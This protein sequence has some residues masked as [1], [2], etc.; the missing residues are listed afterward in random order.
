MPFKALKKFISISIIITFISTNSIYASPDFKPVLKN[1]EEKNSISA[2]LRVPLFSDPDR[3]KQAIRLLAQTTDARPIDVVSLFASRSEFKNGVKVKGRPRQDIERDIIQNILDLQILGEKPNDY[4]VAADL[5]PT[6]WAY[7]AGLYTHGEMR[8]RPF[9]ENYRKYILGNVTQDQLM[10][11]A[12]Q[13]AREDE[14]VRSSITNTDKEIEEYIDEKVVK[15]LEK[16]VTKQIK[17]L[18]SDSVNRRLESIGNNEL[19][20]VCDIERNKL[21]K[22]RALA[23]DSL[24]KIEMA[25]LKALE[26]EAR[27]DRLKSFRKEEINNRYAEKFCNKNIKRVANAIAAVLD[28]EPDILGHPL[29]DDLT[30]LYVLNVVRTV[31]KAVLLKDP[32]APTFDPYAETNAKANEIAID[33]ARKESANSVMDPKEETKRLM[34]FAIGGGVIDLNS[35]VLRADYKADPEYFIEHHFNKA[36]ATEFAS[37]YFEEDFE[38][39]YEETVKS[40]AKIR[41]V[42]FLD[43][44]GEAV[45]DLMLMWQLMRVNPNLSIYVVP[46]VQ[47]LGNDISYDEVIDIISGT[48][49]FGELKGMLGK[50]FYIIDKGPQ[51]QGVDGKRISKEL[52]DVLQGGPDE[53]T[54]GMFAG[55]ANFETTQGWNIPRYYKLMAKGAGM[56]MATGLPQK[57]QAFI[58][59]YVPAGVTVGTGDSYLFRKTDL[60][61]T[62]EE[63]YSSRQTLM[64]FE[65]AVHSKSYRSRVDGYWRE[66]DVNERIIEQAFESGK[67]FA[68]IV[69]S[70]D[71]ELYESLIKLGLVKRIDKA[72]LRKDRV[73]EVILGKDGLK[74]DF[75]KDVERLAGIEDLVEAQR[76]PDNEE[77]EK[78]AYS[79]LCAIA[80]RAAAEI[81]KSWA[82]INQEEFNRTFGSEQFITVAGRGKRFSDLVHKGLFI[83]LQG[84]PNLRLAI[85]GSYKTPGTKPTIFISM[86]QLRWIL[87]DEFIP[88]LIKEVEQLGDSDKLPAGWSEGILPEDKVDPEKRKK[89]FTEDAR[90]IL[91]KPYGPGYYL[92][93]G[94]AILAEKELLDKTAYKQIVFGEMGSVQDLKKS[95]ASLITYMEAVIGN[96]LITAGG[97]KAGRIKKGE[98]EISKK[99]NFF[100]EDGK[101]VAL[102]DWDYIT[103]DGQKEL[104]R[105]AV[106]LKNWLVLPGREQKRLRDKFAIDAKGNVLINSNTVI[107]R[108]N[109]AG[110]FEAYNNRKDRP[111]DKKTKMHLDLA[112]DFIKLVTDALKQRKFNGQWPIGF[113][114]VGEAPSSLKDMAKQTQFSNQYRAQLVERLREL[115]DDKSSD[116]KPISVEEDANP[117]IYFGENADFKFSDLRRIF[118]GTAKLSGNVYL[119]NKVRIGKGAA[120]SNG[121]RLSGE[122]TLGDSVTVSK[123]V[124]EGP[125]EI[126][127]GCS[128]NGTVVC[129]GSSTITENITGLM[130]QEVSLAEAL[131]NPSL[132]YANNEFYKTIKDK[133]YTSLATALTYILGMDGGTQRAQVLLEDLSG[134]SLNDYGK[135]LRKMIIVSPVLEKQLQVF[136]LIMSISNNA[137]ILDYQS[138]GELNHGII[139]EAIDEKLFDFSKLMHSSR[140][141]GLYATMY[142]DEWTKSQEKTLEFFA[143]MFD[144][145]G[146]D[147][148]KKR[149]IMVDLIDHYS[150]TSDDI[151]KIY[152]ATFKEDIVQDMVENLGNESVAKLVSVLIGAE[153]SDRLSIKSKEESGMKEAKEELKR[154]LELVL[155]NGAYQ[156]LLAIFGNVRGTINSFV[157]AVIKNT[158]QTFEEAILADSNPLYHITDVYEKPRILGIMGGTGGTP[159]LLMENLLS[160]LFRGDVTM[161]VVGSPHDDGGSSRLAQDKLKAYGGYMPSPGDSMNV[162]SALTKKEGDVAEAKRNVIRTRFAKDLPPDTSFREKML[163]IL[164]NETKALIGKGLENAPIDW[165]YFARYTLNI[166]GILD[167]ELIKPGYITLAGGSVGNFIFIA[168]HIKQK[169]I[170][171]AGRVYENTFNDS[172]EK[173][174]Q[175]LGLSDNFILPSTLDPATLYAKLEAFELLVDGKSVKCKI[176]NEE[177]KKESVE[178]LFPQMKA[179]LQSGGDPIITTVG[180]KVIELNKYPDSSLLTCQINGIRARVI[181]DFGGIISRENSKTIVDMTW[182]PEDKKQETFK[183]KQ[184]N[185]TAHYSIIEGRLF[186]ALVENTR[187]GD[188][189]K[190]KNYIGY[191]EEFK[192]GKPEDSLTARVQISDKKSDKNGYQVTIRLDAKGQGTTVYFKDTPVILRSRLIIEQ[193]NITESVHTSGIIDAGLIDRASPTPNKKVLD[194]I[195]NTQEAIVLGPGSLM[196]STLPVL[197]VPEIVDAI[198]KR[199]KEGLPVIFIVNPYMDNETVDITIRRLARIFEKTTGRKIE[200]LFTHMIINDP[201]KVPEKMTQ[202]EFEKFMHG[203]SDEELAKRMSKTRDAS[204]FS[205]DAKK[206][207]G[208]LMITEDEM[209]DLMGKV[210]ILV[211]PLAKVIPLEVRQAG[212]AGE[213][214]GIG[215]DTKK[216][217]QSIEFII[218]E[219]QLERIK[220]LGLYQELLHRYYQYYSDGKGSDYQ[221]DE[222]SL[223][224][225]IR[226]LLRNEGWIFK[227][228]GIMRTP[229]EVLNEIK[230]K[231]EE[232]LLAYITS[233]DIAKHPPKIII[234]NLAHTLLEYRPAS[235]QR[236]MPVFKVS[237]RMALGINQ[238]LRSGGILIVQ[239]AL[240]LKEIKKELIQHLEPELIHR[241]ILA[242]Y[243]G[244]QIWRFDAKGNLEPTP[245]KDYSSV[246]SKEQQKLWVDICR[247]AEQIYE[248]DRYL[249]GP[250]GSKPIDRPVVM[251]NRDGKLINFELENRTD[252]PEQVVAELNQKLAKKDRPGLKIPRIK[253]IGVLNDIR[254]AIIEYLNL[255]FN[256]ARL[257]IVAEKPSGSGAINTRFK[258]VDRG[259]A[260]R[261]VLGILNR[262]QI[263]KSEHIYEE[264][265][266]YILGKGNEAVLRELPEAQGVYFREESTASIPANVRIYNGKYGIHG[267]EEFFSYLMRR[268]FSSTSRL[269]PDFVLNSSQ[270][271]LNTGL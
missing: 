266:I 106:Q 65:Q 270:K 49:L 48:D 132:S 63:L 101:L 76:I 174:A 82:E 192:V 196:T 38:R 185:F 198:C 145:P 52:T 217:G 133:K 129:E 160:E 40:K 259:K 187:T 202:E 22:D 213:Q 197:M 230:S 20:R 138:I 43:N 190:F 157:D 116:T 143:K 173:L 167:R 56:A 149:E 240:K 37:R 235:P 67:T 247:E 100:L 86:H 21:Y 171:E 209:R 96:Y 256:E 30:N 93:K 73:K 184:G 156:E 39:F 5:L 13:K 78:R 124:V 159:T 255:R 169:A 18:N 99:G 47:T 83:G 146:L 254:D 262:E 154:D 249:Y 208:P 114:D 36:G 251:N 172:M 148:D 221:Y 139:V 31:M 108:N 117:V 8:H 102:T 130:Q 193:T 215:Y 165:I 62:G 75:R 194:L 136:D 155:N 134:K 77:A 81:G 126:K 1:N 241:V 44:N 94:M 203:L 95:N 92:G 135:V 10:S 162:L 26:P 144:A 16:L 201:T 152:R 168:H 153:A 71:V 238:Y 19:I 17:K 109:I 271:A 6:C 258:Y 260:I 79:Y 58:F 206:P 242:P 214:K 80:I 205:S 158:S 239:S 181:E 90:I 35:P 142:T 41:L 33:I 252:L 121:V 175:S 9:W 261:D 23:Q 177:G 178:F 223:N 231:R 257:P 72:E 98:V 212:P 183:V 199:K 246:I 104:R 50:R 115:L 250:D 267:V 188:V 218:V 229:L 25:R 42:Y 113:V 15:E 226:R 55:Q 232:I 176:E 4:I 151:K 125:V 164:E 85:N 87:K 150:I 161:A 46:K 195:K 57:M 107:F 32:K 28:W 253:K 210:K 60:E 141:P 59:A 224:Y 244:T 27:K 111:T 140:T 227:P 120:L 234:A 182:D 268:G 219:K 128:L 220:Q 2:K 180:T 131:L 225:D 14:G 74:S 91:C 103:E 110:Y 70:Y 237:P 12:L 112:W 211:E 264:R 122:V 127:A 3:E 191:D 228:D 189:E 29:R 97:K 105:L 84:E 170:T 66:E 248:L 7:K 64:D 233:K 245:K 51:I 118:S 88:G 166:A 222:K 53:K 179:E 54:I 186:L 69:F 269:E 147:I 34:K 265:D 137:E 61:K 68:E 236:K 89:Y 216:L 119:D 163:E 45:F 243:A 11:F 263:N 204:D 207:R 200:D 24:I 123:S